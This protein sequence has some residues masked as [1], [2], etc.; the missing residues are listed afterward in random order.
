MRRP[1]GLSLLLLSLCGSTAASSAESFSCPPAKPGNALVESIGMNTHFMQGW[2]YTD[3]KRVIAMLK[4]LG[5]NQIREGFAGPGRVPL[6]VAARSGIKFN[7][8]IDRKWDNLLI[9]KLEYWEKRFPGSILSIEGPNEV[10]NWP[11]KFDGLDGIP[12]A[13]KFQDALY[14]GVK[15]SPILKHIPIVAMTSYPTFTNVADIGNIH[16]YSRSGDGLLGEIDSGSKDEIDHNPDRKKIW[17]TEA[18]Y[19]TLAGPGYFEGVSEDIQ[20]N[21]LL[22]LLLNASTRD[23]GKVFIYQFLDQY[24]DRADQQGYFGVVSLDWRPKPAYE[25]IRNLITIVSRDGG[26]ASTSRADLSYRLDG[27]PETAAHAVYQLND[28]SWIVAVWDNRRLWDNTTH[29]PV[30]AFE[31][32]VTLVLP[33]KNATLTLFDPVAG[34]AS[35]AIAKGTDRMSFS[36]SGAP[37]LLRVDVAGGGGCKK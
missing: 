5:V 28:R 33:Q 24:T 36:L 9:E 31:T 22:D 34:S 11:V 12:A 30:A 6:E 25:A 16:V 29:R 13:K 32:P 15:A 7:F 27:L 17:I 23:I 3:F 21:L 26:A 19:P 8:V 4:D 14:S 18:G 1:L 35:K 2:Q 37:L 20:A 10:N